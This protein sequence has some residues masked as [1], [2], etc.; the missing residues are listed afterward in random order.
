MTGALGDGAGK[1][2][3]RVESPRSVLA[4]SL[5][6]SP[7]GH[8]TNLSGGPVPVVSDTHVV[9][10]FP[11]A[12]DAAGRQGFVRVVN[13]EDRAGAVTVTAF[14]D[15]G[16]DHGSVKLELGASATAP[17]NSSDL[18]QGN[19]DKGLTGGVGA[20]TGDWRLA[21][22]ADVAV[23]VFAYI[24]H[25]DGFVTSMHDAAPEAGTRHRVAIF[26]PGSNRAQVSSLR[27]INPGDAS[28]RVTITGTDD[29]GASPGRPVRV[30]V[31]PG[32]AR[33]YTAAQL[34][35]GAPDLT[36]ALGDGAGK[37]RLTVDSDRP[38]SAMSLLASPTGHLTNL[39]TAPMR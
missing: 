22:T 26:N 36:G 3:L 32:A 20:G 29:Q 33:T 7:T 14:D 5:L 28:A 21:V 24:R 16:R 34:E 9:P 25:A 39:S 17:F 8:L 2:R 38:I 37:W 6:E 10:L 30:T 18:E 35:E 11:A 15:T 4:M 23:D 13:Q 19:P 31:P 27:L 1:W 12:A